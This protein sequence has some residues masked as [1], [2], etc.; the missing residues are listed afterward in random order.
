MDR[1]IKKFDTQAIAASSQNP[2]QIFV[3]AKE[4]ELKT[5]G[6]SSVGAGF[7]CFVM[8]DH[9]QHEEWKQVTGLTESSGWNYGSVQK[10]GGQKTIRTESWRKGEARHESPAPPAGPSARAYPS[11][12]G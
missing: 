12:G 1:G 9:S 4:G 7:V 3:A 6:I 5:I 2:A 10:L 11:S 8:P